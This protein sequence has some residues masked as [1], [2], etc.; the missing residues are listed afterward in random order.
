MKLRCAAALCGSRG[1][2]TSLVFLAILVLV[3]LA[4]GWEAVKKSFFNWGVFS[5]TFPGLLDAFLL[6]IAIFAWCAPL[7]ALLGL[8]VAICRDIQKPALYPLRLF[9]TVYTDVFRGLP[10]ILV[11]YLVGFG[12]PGLGLPRPWNS[13]YIWGLSGAD[14]RLCG[15]RGRGHSVGHRVDP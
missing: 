4:P 11:I 1:V 8:F 5:K 12:I 14:P 3:P 6:D 10:V 2:S 13:P 9:A 7:I 15:L